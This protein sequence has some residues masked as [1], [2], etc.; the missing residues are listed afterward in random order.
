MTHWTEQVSYS[1]QHDCEMAR[2]SGFDDRSQEHFLYI[3]TGRGFRERR[4]QAI[5]DIQEA[6]ESGH[7]PGEID[8]GR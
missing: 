3:E 7:E 4:E 2:I 8:N 6:I 1:L 5:L